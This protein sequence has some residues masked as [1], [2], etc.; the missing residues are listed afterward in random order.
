VGN[1]DD[2]GCV[3]SATGGAHQPAVIVI[4]DAVIAR[5]YGVS[6]VDRRTFGE[7]GSRNAQAVPL[8][9]GRRGVNAWDV[10]RLVELSRDLPIIEVEIA[11]I[12]E[13]ASVHCC[14]VHLIPPG[15]KWPRESAGPL[16]LPMET[17]HFC[18]DSVPSPD[19]SPGGSCGTRACGEPS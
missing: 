1:A 19:A 6:V 15:L 11:A 7:A 8:L 9:A 12:A 13:V 14:V 4:D 10:D 5:K 3:E 18:A 16:P 2:R 17:D